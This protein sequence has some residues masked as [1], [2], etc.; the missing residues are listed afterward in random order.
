MT[1]FNGTSGNDTLTDIAGDDIYQLGA[2]NDTLY[3]NA[4]VNSA[5]VLAWTNGFNTVISTDGGLSA[6]NHD[7]IV[8]NFSKDY[9]YARKVG[10]DLELSVYAHTQDGDSD[11]GSTDEVGKITLKNAFTAST[12]DRIGRVEG[13]NGFYFEAIAAPLADSYGHTAIYKTYNQGSGAIQFEEWY[14]DSNFQDT[15]SVKKFT[16][17]SARIEYFDSDDTLDWSRIEVTYSSYGTASETLVKTERYNDDDSMSLLALGTIGHDSMIGSG[18]SDW[19]DGGLGNDSLSGGDGNDLLNGGTGNDQLR[20]DA[21]NDTLVGGDG[22]DYLTGGSGADSLVG[23]NGID[24]ADYFYSDTSAGI[25]VNLTTGTATRGGGGDTLSGIEN[26]N[27]SKF[28]DILTGD[29]QKNSLQGQ[30]GA[31]LITG[32]AGNDTLDGGAG[33]DTLLGGTGADVLMGGAGND[34]LDGGVTLDH[35]FAGSDDNFTTYNYATAGVNI[36]LSSITG[37]GST[38]SGTASGDA[39]VGVDTLMNINQIQGSNFND[40]ITGSTALIF[41]HIEGG[42]GN[43]TLDGGAIT[44]TLNGDNGNRVTYQN[45]T[46]AGVTVDLVTGTAVG[47]LGS[48][49]GSDTLFNFDQVRGSNFDDTLLGSNR[50]DKTEFFEGRAGNDYID[51]R[52]GFDTVRYT[53]ATTQVIV[54]LVT[55]LATGA[56]GNDTLV[57]IEGARGG[58]G[59][60]ILIG[61]NA[62]NGITLGD[63]LSETFRG[64]AGNDTIDG[65]Q[66]YDRVDYT[67]STSGAIVTLNDTLD[68]SASD[69]LGGMD[70]LR[71]IEGVRGSIFND[72]LTGSAAAFESFEGLEGNDTINGQGGVDRVDYQYSRA[73]VTVNLTTGL[74]SDGYG[75]TDTLS[76]IENIR[77]SRDFNDT[78]TGTAGNN[79]LEGLGG[80]DT[81]NGGAGADVLIGGGGSDTYYVD[82]AGDVVSETNSVASTGGTDTVYSYLSSYTLGNYIENGRIVTTSTASLTGNSLN[83]V[84]YAGMGNNVINGST[85]TDTLSYLYASAAVTLD[86]SKTTAQATGGSGSDTVSNV[87]SLTG[88]KYN[89]KLTGSS[90][91][92]LLAGGAG[93]DTISGGAGNDVLIGGAGKDNLSGG[94]GNDTFDFNILSELGLS[95]TTRDVIIDFTV[96]QDKID[97]STMDARSTLAGDQA[98][99]FVN[100][101]TTTAGQVRYSGGIVYLNTDTDTAAEYAIELVGTIP[102]SLTAASFVL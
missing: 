67:N 77:G 38:G 21:G 70:V 30:G 40:I 80:T 53:N 93:N 95:S 3:F 96:G 5:G 41:E 58:L 29:A 88:S 16:D 10:A 11:P 75:G 14:V 46:G 73:G 19:F 56:M 68:G 48:N 65:G 86:L 98:F 33:N 51:G 47:A 1:T 81:L 32:L 71:N 49:A 17:G 36:N 35:T 7:R 24:T 18:G 55:G 34:S 76:N 12:A 100:S 50:T 62:A 9:I 102:A 63:G 84:L 13:L 26:I 59:N 61:G 92:N 64:E 8:I 28:S 42:A 83:N 78:L 101:F 31:D 72:V 74:A 97:L 94:S 54:N 45:T 91:A 25:V 85:G 90:A 87:E 79:K 4:S 22:D 15:K 2:G 27:G 89:D 69:G 82:N 20:G 37:D 66:G 52:G 6:P 23:G 44:D 60:D 99:T 43:D 57:G 39:S